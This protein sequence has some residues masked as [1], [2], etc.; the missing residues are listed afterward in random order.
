MCRPGLLEPTLRIT[1]YPQVRKGRT[2]PTAAGI[3]SSLI[4]GAGQMMTGAIPAGWLFLVSIALTAGIVSYATVT[5]DQIRLLEL[6]TQPD[7]LLLLVAIDAVLGVI[8]VASAGNAWHRAGGRILGVGMALLV[9][10][11]AVPHVALGY[12][13]LET[14][15]TLLTVFAQPTALAPASATTTTDPVTTTTTSTTLP[16]VVHTLL[17]PPRAIP[18]S[19]TTSSTTTTTLPFGT[20]RVTVLL[21][22]SDAGPGRP[23]ART[24]AMI[25]ATVNTRTGHTALFGLPR[26]MAGFT[27]SDG[28]EFTG[29]SRGILNEVYMWGQ[30][31]PDRFEGPDPGIAALEDVA[32]TLLGIPIDRYVMVDMI[33]FARL[34]DA[35]GGVEV[36]I[37]NTMRAPLYDRITGDYAMIEFSPGA[38]RLDGDHA[39]AFSRSRTA[40]NDYL[41][42]ARQ[43]CLIGSLIDEA[44][45]LTLMSRLPTLLDVIETSVATDIPLADLPYLINLASN[46]KR[47]EITTV[48]FDLDYRSGAFTG[49]G[50]AIPDVAKIQ[51]TVRD[52]LAEEIDEGSILDSF[53]GDS[54]G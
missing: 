5:L 18:T 40:S 20:D 30:R 16:E 35:I 12:L 24:D 44:G 48:G 23:G 6:V 41:R 43:R 31:N 50:Y 42:M 22:G 52:I 51:A 7:I 46:M 3:A 34:V 28:T 45:P 27:F 33:G 8:R 19:S 38:Q 14:R 25:V 36:N 15:S 9:L 54:C 49:N 53:A 10:F 39:L 1:R 17:V 2:S 29:F 26:N 21:V 37:G 4:P 13:G 11:T 32:Q 47:E